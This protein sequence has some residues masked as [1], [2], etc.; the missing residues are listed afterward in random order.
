VA[1]LVSL[2]VTRQGLMNMIFVTTT[3]H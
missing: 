2:M 3:N 1:K